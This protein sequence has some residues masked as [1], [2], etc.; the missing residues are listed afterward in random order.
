MGNSRLDIKGRAVSK[1]SVHAVLRALCTDLL[2]ITSQLRSDMIIFR[3]NFLSFS[4]IEYQDDSCQKFSA[5]GAM[6]K[7]MVRSEVEPQRDPGA[8]VGSQG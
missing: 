6:T 1:S 2:L 3:I 8:E 4:K 7:S 5:S